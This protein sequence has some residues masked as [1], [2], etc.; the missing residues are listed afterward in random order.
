MVPFKGL[1][2]AADERIMLV[3]SSEAF[4]EAR[5]VFACTSGA[6]ESGMEDVHVVGGMPPVLVF[7]F[8]I[9]S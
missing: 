6:Q 5:C 8:V 3:C 1:L 7:C 9:S 4:R 2:L